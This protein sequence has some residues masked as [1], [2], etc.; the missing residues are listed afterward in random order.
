MI[1]LQTQD[2]DIHDD[3]SQSWQEMV[4][5]ISEISRVPATLVNRAYPKDLE[6]LVKS[7]TPNNPFKAKER[8][9]LGIG[10][11]C[12]AIITGKKQLQIND[13]MLEP[14]WR[15]SPAAKAGMVA[16]LGLPLSWPNGDIFGTICMLDSQ[17]MQFDN[18]TKQLLTRFQTII[19]TDLKRVY[20]HAQLLQENKHLSQQL[21]QT[22]FDIEQLKLQAKQNAFE[23]I[24]HANHANDD[25]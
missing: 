24:Y 18:P 8:K 23:Q 9:R 11:Y 16:Y 20:Q 15:D 5:L 22:S 21:N 6:L 10:L 17:P 25:N 12:E 2:I 3:I 19:E 13:A 14:N 7:N 1:A 4:D